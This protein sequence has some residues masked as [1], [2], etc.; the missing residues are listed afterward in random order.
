MERVKQ[1]SQLQFSNENIRKSTELNLIHS[2]N[3][4]MPG[5][6]KKVTHT[7]NKPAAESCMFV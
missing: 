1:T 5:G 6:I 3:L 4:L 7:L 2:F